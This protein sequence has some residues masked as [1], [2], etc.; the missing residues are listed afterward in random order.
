MWLCSNTALFTKTGAKLDLA[1][2]S[3]PAN[4]SFMI[5][6]IKSSRV[7]KLIYSDRIQNSASLKWGYGGKLIAEEQ[8]RIFWCEINV[9]YLD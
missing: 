4:L 8:E 5:L 9:L 2:K 1:Y 3:Y 6:F 7:G